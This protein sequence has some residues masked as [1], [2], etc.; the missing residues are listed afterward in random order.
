MLDSYQEVAARLRRGVVTTGTS[1]GRLV[2]REDWSDRTFT[3]DTLRL[4]AGPRL[5]YRPGQEVLILAADDI[6]GIGY[7]LGVLGRSSGE[8]ETP[9]TVAASR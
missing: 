3:C 1:D 8:P 6:S 2:V 5:E 4:I 9:P 7:V